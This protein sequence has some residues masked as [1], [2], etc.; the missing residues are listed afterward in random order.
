MHSHY[1]TPREEAIVKRL[2][3]RIK[4]AKTSK[5]IQN[6]LNEAITYPSRAVG[7]T[8]LRFHFERTAYYNAQHA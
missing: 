1:L 5:G 4:A 7:D 2:I 6:A 3:K 8:V